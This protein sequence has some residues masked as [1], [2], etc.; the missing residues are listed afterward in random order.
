VV[1]VRVG[2]LD[3]RDLVYVF[4]ILYLRLFECVVNSVQESL[5]YR[6]LIKHNGILLVE[7]VVY[8]IRNHQLL[9]I[10]REEVVHNGADERRR[11]VLLHDHAFVHAIGEVIHGPATR[12]LR[13]IGEHSNTLSLRVISKRTQKSNDAN[14]RLRYEYMREVVLGFGVL[15]L[16][17]L[18][19]M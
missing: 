2:R 1:A 18:H 16:F 6:A 11:D 4:V 15:S 10:R 9:A 14:E 12:L 7:A 5:V 19:L 13:L 8:H 3:A 17:G